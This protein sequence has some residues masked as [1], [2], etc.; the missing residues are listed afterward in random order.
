MDS[1]R[2][3][4]C[5]LAGI[6]EGEGTAALRF[7]KARTTKSIR[8]QYLYA[9]ISQVNREMLEEVQRIAGVGKIYST[10]PRREG[11][12]PLFTWYIACANARAFLNRL[13]PF[14][15]A[16]H[17]RDQVIVALAKDIEARAEGARVIKL[18][19]HQGRTKRWEDYRAE[20][21]RRKAQV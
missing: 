3:D 2:E 19:L 20:I 8:R 16:P 1:T 13:L 12:Q 14:M 15:R 9:A 11:R 5:W 18:T 21:S 7:G 4:W 17:K 10:V 6:F